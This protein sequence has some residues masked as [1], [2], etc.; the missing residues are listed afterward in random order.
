MTG[1]GYAHKQLLKI[2]EKK[3]N[4]KNMNLNFHEVKCIVGYCD[5]FDIFFLLKMFEFKILLESR[6]Y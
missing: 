3:L 5:E 2:Y 6:Y 4:S 1:F